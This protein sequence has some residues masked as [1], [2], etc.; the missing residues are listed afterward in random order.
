MNAIRRTK[1]EDGTYLIEQ[2]T[3]CEVYRCEDEDGVFFAV[4]D[5]GQERVDDGWYI[6]TFT[7]RRAA[8]KF[9]AEFGWVEVEEEIWAAC[10]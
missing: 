7:T 10:Q 1:N 2:Y 9:A 4:S 8:E 5:E 6:D 3:G